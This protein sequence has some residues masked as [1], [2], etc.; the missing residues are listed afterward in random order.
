MIARPQ[1]SF[2]DACKLAIQKS[3]TFTGR[4]RRSE[5]WWAVLGFFIA[6]MI[7]SWIPF[8]GNLISLYIAIASIALG[9]R[10]LHDTGHS[11]WLF[12]AN[13]ILGLLGIGVIIAA[14]FGSISLTDAIEDSEY[15]A[16]VIVNSVEESVLPFMLGGLLL[17]VSGI[18]QIIIFIFT[19]FD[20][21]LQANKYGESPK[22]VLEETQSAA[23]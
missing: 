7:L 12:G 6:D 15:L 8:V 17:A 16:K 13:I 2:L 1:V 9:F 5:Y 4:I 20:S 3:F 21:D 22:Y 19:L 11:G 10:R 14:I 18:I 23:E